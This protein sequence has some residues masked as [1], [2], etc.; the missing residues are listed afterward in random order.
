MLKKIIVAVLFI[1]SHFSYAV[2]QQDTT[3]GST[4]D[5][6]KPGGL[7]R[8]FEGPGLKPTADLRAI[9]GIS[10][11]FSYKIEGRVSDGAAM[12]AQ[13]IKA[14]HSLSTS[15]LVIAYDAEFK[16][17][18]GN[19]DILVNAIADLNGNIMNYFGRGN[20]TDFERSGDFRKFYR[21]NFSFYRLDP[22]FRFSLGEGLTLT[23][24]PSLQYFVYGDNDGRFIDNPSL[25]DDDPNLY[26]EK[27]H[28]GLL[29][30]FNIDK[31]DDIFLPTRGY[32]FNILL[33]GYEGLNSRS[34]SYA[35]LFPQVSFY[36]AL[37]KN[38]SITLAN[39]TGAG[40][41]KGTTAFYQ[42]AFLGSEDAL[43][44]FRKNRF[45]GETTLY[46][47]LEARIELPNIFRSLIPGKMGLIGFY[48]VG[49]VW[50]KGEDSDT[51]HQGVGGGAFFIPF[52]KVFLRGVA[53]FSKEGMQATVAVR[54]RF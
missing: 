52:N 1:A 18:F 20:D 11:G 39:R 38:G 41:T 10:L 35:Q 25:I 7:K 26:Q 40:F 49:R 36:K 34:G 30:N 17:A 8:L 43:L 13:K 3:A 54:Q 9:D 22:A 33:Q 14:L 31:R 15:S 24:G 4:K 2:A 47:N 45:A 12:N 6:S 46:N 50:V 42:H 5:I 19:T 48:D 29:L 27:A 28:G 23:A 51:I 21:T 44:G 37:D 32:K 53:G 16:K